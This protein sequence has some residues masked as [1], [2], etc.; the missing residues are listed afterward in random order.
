VLDGLPSDT[1]PECGRV[2][3]PD[4]SSTFHRLVP[5][6][7]P[8]LAAPPAETDRFIARLQERKIPALVV[9]RSTGD[10][11][12]HDRSEISVARD[13]LPD[14]LAVAHDAFAGRVDERW[15]DCPH[16]GDAVPRYLA[17]CWSCGAARTPP[18]SER[19]GIRS[20]QRPPESSRQP[21]KKRPIPVTLRERLL[22][23]AALFF[24]VGGV[25]QL[26][27]L[28]APLAFFGAATAIVL[29]LAIRIG[30]IVSGDPE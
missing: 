28:A 16:C 4:D 7:V 2:F 22:L 14:A 24:I 20:V 11:I 23:Y 5:A 9:T 26:W 10:A 17:V 1:C 25:I 29:F 21:R 8:L 6:Q 3:D 13:D 19:P 15:W 30:K 12:E 27:T 18:A